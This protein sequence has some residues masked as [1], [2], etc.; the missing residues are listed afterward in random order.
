MHDFALVTEGATDHAIL[1]NILLGYF[2]EQR[3]PAV[4]REH[5]DP[6]A[7]AASGGW[8]LLLQY[9]RDKKFRQ[10][11]QLNRFLIIQV[12]TDI[13]QERGFDVPHQDENG[14]LSVVK[15]VE[16]VIRRLRTEIGEPDLSTSAGRFIFAVAVHQIECWVLPLWF[17][18]AH[19][20]KITG[21][22]AT[23]GQCLS[24][25]ERLTQ[26]GLR[27][28]RAEEKD[29]RSYD[30]ASRG[31]RKTNILREEGRKNPSL[32]LFLH[33]L[34]QRGLILPPEE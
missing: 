23:L 2:R 31:F 16:N 27:W 7:E 15:L 9:L 32:A 1:T 14:P 29:A 20:E 5:P 34:D 28:I 12:D 24:L 30:E 21:C 33:D 3:E 4:N 18:D 13:S 10:A 19:A 25:R 8:T 17:S 6:Q 22:V 26:K 11:F